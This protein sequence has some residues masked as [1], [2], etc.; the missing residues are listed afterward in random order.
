[1]AV[2]VEHIMANLTPRC[3]WECRHC[4]YECGPNR[5]GEIPIGSLKA[6]LAQMPDL[7]TGRLVL[8]GGEA[9]LYPHLDEAISFAG[10]LKET[11]GY[12]K[13]IY[14]L[15][16]GFWAGDFD[17]ALLTIKK[18]KELGLTH[19]NVSN[20]KYHREFNQERQIA[21]LSAIAKHDGVPK[22]EITSEGGIIPLGKA[23]QGISE[24]EMLQHYLDCCGLTNLAFANRF[25]K[26]YSNELFIFSDGVYACG[27]KVGYL[28]KGEKLA[29]S[30]ESFKSNAVFQVIGCAGPKGVVD[31]VK[32][33]MPASIVQEAASLHDC[34]VC[35]DILS[36][37]EAVKTIESEFPSIMQKVEQEWGEEAER[38]RILEPRLRALEKRLSSGERISPELINEFTDLKRLMKIEW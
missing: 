31:F 34:I 36:N 21:N 22:I 35:Y 37:K 10:K 30:V 24:K 2:T 20:D 28:G 6:Y 26:E 25:P 11:T 14:M 29:E 1:M 8:S 13:K 12:P 23:R 18:W 15:T 9:Y 5:T 19:L 4:I 7:K 16:N 33:K 27:N 17:R 3:T 32:E 38:E